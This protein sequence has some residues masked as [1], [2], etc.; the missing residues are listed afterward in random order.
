MHWTVNG[1]ADIVALRCQH[2]SG[3]WDELVPASTRH[4]PGYAPSSDRHRGSDTEA[5]AAIKI[6]PN[7]PCRAPVVAPIV[8]ARRQRLS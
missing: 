7:N 8:G 4:Q 1:A 5:R 3:R 2:R 6:I